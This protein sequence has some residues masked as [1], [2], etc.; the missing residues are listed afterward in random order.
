[1]TH[2]VR[3]DDEEAEKVPDEIRYQLYERHYEV[4]VRRCVLEMRD[5]DFDDQERDRDRE[6]RV[7]EEDYSFELESLVIHA[8]LKHKRLTMLDGRFE[9]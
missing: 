4:T 6:D 5:F 9:F 1:M 8:L 2:P 3:T 7:A